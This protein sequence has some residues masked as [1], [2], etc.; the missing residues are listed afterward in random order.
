MQL[1]C[2]EQLFDVTVDR[3]GGD[4]NARVD[5]QPLRLSLRADGEGRV[6]VEGAGESLTLH[7]AR[8]GGTLHMFWDGVAYR[9]VEAREGARRAER[10]ET[11]ALEAP[12]PGRVSALKVEVGQRVTKGEELLVVEAMKMENEIV[13][14]RD[15]VV[16]GLT[17]APGDAV[18]QG[19]PICTVVST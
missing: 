15:G 4:W 14:H 7:F 6:V 13:S 17:I 9:L 2:G 11:G 18:A 12:M 8:D 10:H 16:T 1:R 3:A 19:Q 5:G